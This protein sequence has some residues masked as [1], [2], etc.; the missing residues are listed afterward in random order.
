MNLVDKFNNYL[1]YLSIVS[2][3]LGIYAF[4]NNQSVNKLTAQ[5]EIERNKLTALNNK[6]QDLLQNKLNTSEL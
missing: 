4:M 6:Y 2:V 1:K 5:I 3:S